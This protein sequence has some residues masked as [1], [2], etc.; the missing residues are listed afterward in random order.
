[1]ILARICARHWAMFDGELAA[2]GAGPLWDM[3]V[4]RGLNMIYARVLEV[5]TDKAEREDFID[6]MDMTADEWDEWLT[7]KERRQL[8]MLQEWGEVA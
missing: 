2:K 6:N 7:W 8:A 3:P 1:M 4:R 5:V